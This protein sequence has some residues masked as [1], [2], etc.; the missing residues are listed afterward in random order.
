MTKEE[1]IGIFVEAEKEIAESDIS[2]YIY[3]S[4]KYFKCGNLKKMEYNQAFG[5]ALSIIGKEHK[6]TPNS[7]YH[8]GVVYLAKKAG[9]SSSEI[10]AIRKTF[11]HTGCF[12]YRLPYTFDIIIREMINLLMGIEDKKNIETFAERYNGYSYRDTLIG[13]QYRVI[14]KA[15]KEMENEMESVSSRKIDRITKIKDNIKT[16]TEII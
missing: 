2:D 8:N 4:H 5:A 10:K 13:K 9:V 14:V 1:I 16:Y 12:K 6:L 3:L 11:G 7:N 15:L